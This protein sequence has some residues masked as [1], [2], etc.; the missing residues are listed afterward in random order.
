MIPYIDHKTTPTKNILYMPREIPAVSFVLIVLIAW[1]T[2]DIVVSAA[3]IRPI[4]SVV[5]IS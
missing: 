1:G 5:S 3:A 4:I 2:K